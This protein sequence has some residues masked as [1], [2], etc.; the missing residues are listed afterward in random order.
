MSDSTSGVSGIAEMKSTA[1][2]LSSFGSAILYL[3]CFDTWEL[4]LAERSRKVE[5]RDIYND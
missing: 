3:A 5:K 1:M 2:L 4:A